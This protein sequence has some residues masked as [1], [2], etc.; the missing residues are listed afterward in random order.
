MNEELRVNRHYDTTPLET[1]N[2]EATTP[3]REALLLDLYKEICSSWRLLTDVRFKLLGL[4]P[5][6]SV[7]ILLTLL[8]RTPEEASPAARIAIALFG[9]IVTIGLYIYDQ[10]NSELYDDLIS[11]GRKIEEELGVDTGQFRGRRKPS[12]P[13]INH[14][15]ATRLIYGASLAGWLFAIPGILF[16]W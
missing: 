14:S 7:V 16:R 4:I 2:V 10:R 12:R 13:L 9:L 11:R 3:A 1:L 5:I 8:G 6:I 15:N